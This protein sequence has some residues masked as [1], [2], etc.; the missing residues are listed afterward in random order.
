M[1]T[2]TDTEVDTEVT[3]TDTEPQQVADIDEDTP[4]DE[5]EPTDLD[6]DEAQDDDEGDMFPRAYVDKLRKQSARYR[7]QARKSTTYAQRLHTE[8]VRATGKLADPTDLG[9][10]EGHLDDTDALAVA[11]DELL[12][13]KPH[14]ASRRPTGDI[15]QGQRG[16]G[17]QPFSLLEAL[18]QR[19]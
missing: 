13:R 17:G 6:D 3:D 14:L 11:I 5:A 4:A 9:F 15:G 19:T 1:N 18:K 16:G 2:D 7:D 12:T 10:D 8:L